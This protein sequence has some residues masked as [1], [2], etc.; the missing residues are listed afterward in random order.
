MHPY[1]VPPRIDYRDL[2]R[3]LYREHYLSL[4]DRYRSYPEP[5]GDSREPYFSDPYDPMGPEAIEAI[6]ERRA[7][8]MAAARLD[9]YESRPAPG[10]S[11]DSMG[12]PPPDYYNQRGSRY[13]FCF[14][15]QNAIYFDLSIF[16]NKKWDKNIL[17]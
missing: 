4:L 14:K 16:F 9:P 6:A 7:L 13:V 3:N 10:P 15:W 8:R 11:R 5:Y 17:N 2:Y 12:R 1:P